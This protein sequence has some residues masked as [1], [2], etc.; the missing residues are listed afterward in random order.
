MKS[1][2]VFRADSE[3]IALHL[4]ATRSAIGATIATKA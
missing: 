1:A 4:C 2:A 3:K